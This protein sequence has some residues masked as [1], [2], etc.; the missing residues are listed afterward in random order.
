MKIHV[1]G[2]ELLRNQDGRNSGAAVLPELS[3]LSEQIYWLLTERLLSLR[4][5]DLLRFSSL[6]SLASFCLWARILEYSAAARRFLSALLLFRATL[7]LFLWRTAGVTRRWT[8]GALNFCFLPSFKGRGLLMTYWQTSSSFDRL[9][10]LRILEAL[11]GPRRL[12]MV[13]SV[14]PGMSA[15]PFLTMER[16]RTDKLPSTM[17]PRTDL[18]LRSPV[19]RGR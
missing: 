18:R 6:A 9:K 5:A 19:R 14:R 2:D 4:E 8:L 12:G 16:A 3:L 10:S 1:Q 17:H 15:A 7:C 13:V 11:L